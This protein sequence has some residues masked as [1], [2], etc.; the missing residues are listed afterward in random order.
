MD[1]GYDE[2]DRPCDIE[3]LSAAVLDLVE[4]LSPED[5]KTWC[6]ARGVSYYAR[7]KSDFSEREAL[8]L[9]ARSRCQYLLMEDLS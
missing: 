1:V 4:G 2:K 5:F 3:V 8:D 7:P 6:N 9:C